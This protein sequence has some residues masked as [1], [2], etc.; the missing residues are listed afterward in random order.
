MINHSPLLLKHENELL[1]SMGRRSLSAH[2]TLASLRGRARRHL[3]NSD[4]LTSPGL[5]F[6]TRVKFTMAIRSYLLACR[7]VAIDIICLYA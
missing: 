1:S 4:F 7:A 5:Y 3:L 6:W 2:T